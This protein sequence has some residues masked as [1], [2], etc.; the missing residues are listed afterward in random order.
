AGVAGGLEQAERA[1][2]EVAVEEARVVDAD[3]L[4]LAGEVVFALLDEGLGHGAHVLDPTVEPERGVDAVC[5]QVARDTG[6]GD[7]D[8]EAP[9]AGAA[10]RELGIDGPVLQE[11]GA[12]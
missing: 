8:V 1:V 2:V 3:L 7:F 6:T 11:V 5:E 4:D 9:E 12:V 10:L